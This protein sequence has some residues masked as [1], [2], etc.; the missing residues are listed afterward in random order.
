MVIM[1]TTSV[2]QRKYDNVLDCKTISRKENVKT[3][4][5][6]RNKEDKIQKSHRGTRD[7]PLQLWP[8]CLDLSYVI[9]APKPPQMF[10]VLAE[11]GLCGIRRTGTSCW[12]EIFQRRWFHK[13]AQRKRRFA[14]AI[15]Y[16]PRIH[17]YLTQ[18]GPQYHVT[19]RRCVSL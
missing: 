4:S 13:E 8:A 1:S 14:T 10:S 12:K 3:I 16:S 11:Q 15:C 18:A 17:T 5:D 7:H 19:T 6:R 2:V 9:D